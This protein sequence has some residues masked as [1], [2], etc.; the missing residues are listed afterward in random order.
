MARGHSRDG[1]TAVGAGP[2]WAEPTLKE[3]EPNYHKKQ[4]FSWLSERTDEVHLKSPGSGKTTCEHAHG[5]TRTDTGMHTDTRTHAHTRTHRDTHVDTHMHRH[6]WTRMDTHGH[7]DAHAPTD[8]DAHA[9]TVGNPPPGQGA[10]PTR[11]A[12]LSALPPHAHLNRCPRGPA[13]SSP[14][15]HT[16]KSLQWRNGPET[17][18]PPVSSENLGAPRVCEVRRGLRVT[19]PGT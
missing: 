19:H 2:R 18:P 15:V 8:T 5:H 1:P 11:W 13:F 14:G 7:T 9:D 4:E 16:R 12:L 6:A 17:G 3:Q 10:A